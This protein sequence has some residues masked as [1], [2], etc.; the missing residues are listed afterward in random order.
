MAFKLVSTLLSKMLIFAVAS[1]EA[2]LR[3]LESKSDVP[4]KVSPAEQCKFAA[5]PHLPYFWDLDCAIGKLGCFADGKHVQCRF[6]GETPYTGIG[7]PSNAVVPIARVCDFDNAP[8]T[9]VYWEPKCKVGMKGCFADSKHRGCRFC[10][11]DNYTDIECPPSVCS[12]DNEPISPY[13]WDAKCQMGMLGCNADGI[14]AQCR[15]CAKMPFQN[16]ECPE[17]ARPPYGECWFPKGVEQKHYWDENCTW[18]MPG[19]WADGV[20]AQCRFC[21]SGDYANITCPGD[22]RI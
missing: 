11:A 16:I 1:P 9:P 3:G 2:N 18:G 12:F 8:I 19:C 6:C 7:C 17:S 21:G 15:F 5:P 4:H 22:L 10:G 14:H 20:H 13:Y